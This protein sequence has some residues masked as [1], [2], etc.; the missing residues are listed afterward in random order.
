MS[1]LF[2]SLQVGLSG[3]EASQQQLDLVGQDVANANTP[4]YVQERLQV[5][6]LSGMSHPGFDQPVGRTSDGGVQVVGT[7]RLGDAFLQGQSLAQHSASGS[8]GAQQAALAQIQQA[9]P[10]PSTNGLSQMF[11]TFFNSWDTLA[12]NPGDTATRQGVLSAG[13]ALTQG[14]NAAATTLSSVGANAGQQ[15]SS[16]VATVNT[17]A[18]QIAAL[19]SS[20]QAATT[21]GLAAGP[22]QDQRDQLVSQLSDQV[23]VRVQ[24]NGDGTVNLYVGNEALVSGTS[25]QRLAVSGSGAATTL[26]WSADGSAL[27][28]AGGTIGGL[29]TVLTSTVPTLSSSL[30][31]VASSL[32]AAVNAAQAAGVT[33]GGSPGQPFFTGTTASGLSVAITDPTQLAAASAS[34]PAP[35]PGQPNLDGSNA[36]LIGE[37]ATAATAAGT[38]GTTVVGPVAAYNELV[39]NLGG[40]AASVNTQATTQAAATSAADTAYSNA[41]GVDTNAELTRMVQYQN[42]YSANAKYISTISTTISSLLSMVG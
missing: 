26:T 41:T 15:I 10:E 8:L 40:L 2:S 4:G 28:A 23:G 24:A 32:A 29:Q 19:N 33:T 18:G 35:A 16:A 3:L 31:A 30:D 13:Q 6:A 36:A 34:A 11:T 17:L 20:I 38:G 9:F 27:Q 25:S 1:D 39:T 21:G 22:L 7:Q 37:L 5:A 12:T 14:L 42:S